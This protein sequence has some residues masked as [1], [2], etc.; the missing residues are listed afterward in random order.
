MTTNERLITPAIMQEFVWEALE[1]PECGFDPETLGTHLAK[2]LTD[3]LNLYRGYPRFVPVAGDVFDRANHLFVFTRSENAACEIADELNG[4]RSA[5]EYVW[6]R[7]TLHERLRVVERAEA[8]HE[9]V[10]K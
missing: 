7:Y 4:G 5:A 8:T 9:G 3:R 6:E 10:P 1:D 2:Q